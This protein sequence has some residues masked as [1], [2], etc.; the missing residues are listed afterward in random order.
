M[1]YLFFNVREFIDKKLSGRTVLSKLTSKKQKNTQER[2]F[3]LIFFVS[4]LSAFM[5]FLQFGRVNTVTEETHVRI[6]P[7]P[8][9]ESQV[10]CRF[11][12]VCGHGDVDTVSEMRALIVSAVLLSSCPLHFILVSDEGNAKRASQM[13]KALKTMKKSVSVDIWTIS[14]RFITKWATKFKFS[15]QGHLP[16]KR[17]WLITKVYLPYLLQ[18]FDR[19]VVIDTDMI[20]LD[21]PAI[22]WNEFHTS[23]NQKW[24]YKMPLSN[25]SSQHTICSCV[26]LINVQNVITDNLYPRQFQA[27]LEQDRKSYNASSGLYQTERVDQAVY[28]YLRRIR[29]DLFKSLDRRFNIDHCHRYYNRLAPDSHEQ[30]TLLHYNC[31]EYR[32][33]YHRQGNGLF[34]FFQMY[35]WEWLKGGGARTYPIRIQQF[36]DNE[37]EAM[38][39][40]NLSE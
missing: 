4:V 7:R 35:H 18:Q 1:T 11:V 25:L 13:F 33:K 37:Q 40:F 10:V 26:V 34:H 29:P 6:F 23:G 22:L 39:R 20:F 12:L 24:A 28:F 9:R 27:A 8:K 14:I 17:V 2:L 19:I 3:K 16:S 21:D 15:P 5:T 38:M 36:R 32:F 30:V 31:P